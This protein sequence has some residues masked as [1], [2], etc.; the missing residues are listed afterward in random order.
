MPTLTVI[1][2]IQGE[3]LQEE[4]NE[5]EDDENDNVVLHEN[6]IGDLDKYYGQETMN[7]SILYSRGYASESGD[8]GPDEEVDEE[9]F[10]TK[11]AEAFK[12]VLRRDHRPPLFERVKPWLTTTK[13]Y[14]LEFGQL[15][16]RMNM[17]KTVFLRGSTED[18]VG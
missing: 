4:N 13:T 15:L 8:D 7:N 1:S 2:N 16:T 17:G 6:N 18:V 9:G 12:K 11:E 14:C 10:M 5:H 3:A